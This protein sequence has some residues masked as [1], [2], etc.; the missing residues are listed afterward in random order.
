MAGLIGGMIGIGVPAIGG[1][2]VSSGPATRGRP[3]E[4]HTHIYLG[5]ERI[6]HLVDR[7]SS[8]QLSRLLTST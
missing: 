7:R 6:A 5:G 1:A 3:T 2:P 4:L 8:A